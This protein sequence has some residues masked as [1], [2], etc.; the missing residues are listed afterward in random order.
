MV[1]STYCE[2]STGSPDIVSI[3]P[4]IGSEAIQVVKPLI[5][6]CNDSVGFS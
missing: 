2:M 6:I 4:E 3:E 5:G 1:K